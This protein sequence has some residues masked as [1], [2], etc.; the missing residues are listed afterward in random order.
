MNSLTELQK[1]F[2][3]NNLWHIVFGDKIERDSRRPTVSVCS[4]LLV[5]ALHWSTINSLLSSPGPFGTRVGPPWAV[6]ERVL[7]LPPGR[8]QQRVLCGLS[9]VPRQHE[10]VL[11]QHVLVRLIALPWYFWADRSGRWW[12]CS[13]RRGGET[14]ARHHLQPAHPRH[15]RQRVRKTRVPLVADA[16]MMGKDGERELVVRIWLP[17]IVDS[18]T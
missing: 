4:N 10:P 7:V 3:R 2:C 1:Y 11:H 15:W 18:L 17:Q 13:G 16:A 12:G 9:L 14:L 5:H 8:Q 6:P